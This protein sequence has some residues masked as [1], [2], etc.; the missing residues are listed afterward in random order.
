MKT[1]PIQVTTTGNDDTDAF[2]VLE[3]ALK[4]PIRK[5]AIPPYISPLVNSC[6]N[7]VLKP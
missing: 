3:V 7:H 2:V 1:D 4:N 5:P 6:K